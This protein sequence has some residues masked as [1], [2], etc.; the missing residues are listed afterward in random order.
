MAGIDRRSFLA[1]IAGGTALGGIAGFGA[2]MIVQSVPY[3]NTVN[4]I[5]SELSDGAWTWFN[6][7]RAIS[8]GGTPVVGA[9]SSAGELLVYD[10]D[11]TPTPVDLRGSTFQ[12]DDH[13]NP[14][15]LVRSSDSKII[16]FAAAHDG[17]GFYTYL[18]ANANDPSAF[19]AETNI[20][21]QLGKDGYSYT[22]PIQLTGETNDPIYVFFRAN[23]GTSDQYWYSKST[24][25]GAT[26]GTP[27]QVLENDGDNVNGDYP[28][29]VK[30]VQNGDSRIDFFCTDGHPRDT[31]T[32][33]IYHF[34]YEAGAFK[35]IDGTTLTLP[36]LPSTDLDKIYDG[37]TNRAW[38]W[39]CAVDG[40]GNPVCAYAIFGTTN[41]ARYRYARWNGTSWDDHF[42]CGAGGYL[43][44]VEEYYAGGITIDPDDVD[45]VFCSRGY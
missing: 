11:A 6:D 27:V 24:D 15:F 13:A 29:Y 7:P 33:S 22:N 8:V 39:D 3:P 19:G 40:S 2:A 21:S 43:Y 1:G 4:G 45:V 34:Y 31:A 10:A 30:M 9:I 20:D 37:S 36:I 35:K 38:I 5:A 44:A 14:S 42:V 28:P 41:S 25:Q 32:N 26:W 23:D 17:S 12:L 16:A 18:S